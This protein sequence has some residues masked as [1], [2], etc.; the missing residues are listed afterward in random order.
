[1]TNN[2]ATKYR[3]ALK[4]K[5]R[6]AV[7]Y[8]TRIHE[9]Y[10]NRLEW[11]SYKQDKKA[12]QERIDCLEYELSWGLSEEDLKH[13]IKNIKE[14]TE[15]S[16]EKIQ[17]LKDEIEEK[18]EEIRGLEAEI[19]KLDRKLENLEDDLKERTEERKELEELEKLKEELKYT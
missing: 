13:E 8:R 17:K 6:W 3:E 9:D 1:M 11:E 19:K 18:E 4:K 7:D 2:I 12:L 16:S 10:I 15:E 14:E 5:E